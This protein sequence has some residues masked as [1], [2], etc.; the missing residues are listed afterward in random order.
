M[1]AVKAR[2][3]REAVAQSGRRRVARKYSP[4]CARSTRRARSRATRR[5]TSSTLPDCADPDALAYVVREKVSLS[6]FRQRR[7]HPQHPRRRGLQRLAAVDENSKNCQIIVDVPS[8]DGGVIFEGFF[9]LTQFQITGD[10]GGKME[11][12]ISLLSDGDIDGHGEHLRHGQPGGRDHARLGRGGRRLFRFG[13]GELRKIQEELGAGP[14]RDRGAVHA[15]A[16]RPRGA[17][18]QRLRGLGSPGQRQ[19]GRAGPRPRGLPAGPARRQAELAMGEAEK[20]VREY[21]DERPLAENLAACYRLCMG[22]VLGPEDEP[23]GESG[24]EAASTS[25]SPTESSASPTITAPAPSS[26]SAP[27][28]S[29]TA[30]S[31]KSPPK[32]EGLGPRQRRRRRQRPQ[33]PRPK[34]TTPSRQVRVRPWRTAPFK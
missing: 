30:P 8:A 33:R 21:I 29:T 9:H 13:I 26:D 19:A 7:R 23:L 14:D 4:R 1:A 18:H 31:G 3:G 28:R 16:R 17:A 6:L 32:S 24:G 11:C 5:P 34:S 12:S 10:R 27:A 20:L 25:P 15:L 22:A 2:P